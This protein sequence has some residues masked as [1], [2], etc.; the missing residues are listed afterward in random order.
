MYKHCHTHLT[1]RSCACEHFYCI[2]C[3]KCMF[4]TQQFICTALHTKSSV[5]LSKFMF[6]DKYVHVRGNLFISKCTIKT[7]KAL[8]WKYGKKEYLTCTYFHCKWCKLLQKNS[9]LH[10]GSFSPE[11]LLCVWALSFLLLLEFYS[12]LM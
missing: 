5:W 7:I 3:Y 4:Q 12:N 10:D 11:Y 6:I 8:T 2:T 9:T 1:S